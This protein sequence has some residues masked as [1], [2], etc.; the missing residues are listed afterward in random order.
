MNSPSP[1]R[2]A[3]IWDLSDAPATVPVGLG[4]SSAAQPGVYAGRCANTP[5]AAAALKNAFVRSTHTSWRAPQMSFE[6]ESVAPVS[7][8]EPTALASCSPKMRVSPS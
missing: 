8:A 5:S 6:A 4:G 7:S 3:A 2:K 1:I